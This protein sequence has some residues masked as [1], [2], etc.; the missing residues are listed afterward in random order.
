MCNNLWYIH[1]CISPPLSWLPILHPYKSTG[2]IKVFTNF[3]FNTVD[4]NQFICFGFRHFDS[5]FHILCWV[6]ID[7][8]YRTQILEV[9]NFFKFLIADLD[10]CLISLL[11]PL[12]SFSLHSCSAAFS[13]RL[14][15]RFQQ[16]RQSSLFCLENTDFLVSRCPP[17]S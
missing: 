2:H 16:A 1:I 12:V 17:L 6:S 7:C 3:T 11:V 10:F 15:P 4:I 14:C 13:F 5:Y 9:F 8:F